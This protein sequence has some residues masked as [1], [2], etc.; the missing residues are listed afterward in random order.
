[1]TLTR[2]SFFVKGLGER[3]HRYAR[4]AHPTP[5]IRDRQAHAALLRLPHAEVT[6]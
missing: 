3:V 4:C 5:T 1:M 2:H 6:A